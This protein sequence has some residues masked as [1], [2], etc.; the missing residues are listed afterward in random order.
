MGNPENLTPSVNLIVTILKRGGRVPRAEMSDITREAGYPT[1]G[2]WGG[3]KSGEFVVEQGQE[4]LISP[5]GWDFIE[6]AIL[7]ASRKLYRSQGTD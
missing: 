1:S 3:Y 4:I 6:R 7:V 2:S 5:A